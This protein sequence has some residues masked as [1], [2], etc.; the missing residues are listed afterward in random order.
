MVN[1]YDRIYM[2][3]CNEAERVA[4]GH[5]YNVDLVVTVAMEIVNL[6]DE[7]RIRPI[8]IKK[9]IEECITKAALSAAAYD[10][11]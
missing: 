7:H 6:V 11:E 10:E 2:E 5:Q 1:N 4:D 9:A 3:L 8:R